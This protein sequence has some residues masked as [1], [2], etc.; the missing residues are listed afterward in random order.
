MCPLVLT[1]PNK[2]SFLGI[3]WHKIEDIWIGV[4]LASLSEGNLFFDTCKNWP[5]VTHVIVAGG[6]LLLK[7]ELWFNAWQ[8]Q[9]FSLIHSIQTCSGAH[10]ASCVMGLGFFPWG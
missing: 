3:K 6:L 4:Q 7:K 9:G 8:G 5:F 2:H 10:L 1:F